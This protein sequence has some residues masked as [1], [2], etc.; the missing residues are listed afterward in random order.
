MNLEEIGD[1]W[2]LALADRDPHVI[3]RLLRHSSARAGL[4]Q[5]DERLRSSDT[6]ELRGLLLLGGDDDIPFAADSPWGVPP[7]ANLAEALEHVWA[8]VAG[9]CPRFL[10]ALRAEVLG[11][12]L[13]ALDGEHLLG[14]LYLADRS[15]DLPR[16]LADLPG[17]EHG[18][19][20]IL[21]GAAP[22]R[23]GPADIVPLLDEPL[24]AP[25]RDL[26]AVHASLTSFDFVQRLDRF[27]TTLGASIIENHAG[28]DPADYD[29]DDEFVRATNGEFDRHVRFCT[30]DSAAEAYF[31][32][33]TDRDPD[34]SPR[35]ALSGINGDSEPPGT[36]FWD[37][38]DEAL[39][40]LLFC[41]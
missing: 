13:V 11:M 2:R 10:A 34:G 5:R 36:P 18:K 9:R 38:V 27:T 28:E 30:C 3:A 1:A 39:P 24:P 4:L 32:D 16:T 6:A 22:A 20:E 33:M 29:E 23:L 41:V 40:S 31:L 19:L 17:S 35:V 21:W 25:V 15:Q 7:G 12:A 37:W 14:Y 26:A 8:P